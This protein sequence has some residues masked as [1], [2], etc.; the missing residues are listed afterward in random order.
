MYKSRDKL[1][2][3]HFYNVDSINS[4]KLNY[5]SVIGITLSSLKVDCLLHSDISKK[6]VRGFNLDT[7]QLKHNSLILAKSAAFSKLNSESST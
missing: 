3:F 2:Y 1:F 4:E 7:P 5:Y 6:V